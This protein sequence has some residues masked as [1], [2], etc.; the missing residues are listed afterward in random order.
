MNEYSKAKQTNDDTGGAQQVAEGYLKK[1]YSEGAISA[2]APTTGTT[3]PQSAPSS[4][5]PEPASGKP[6]LKRPDNLLNHAPS[7]TN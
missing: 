1:A 7:P 2:A 5:I 3:T 4:N 6:T